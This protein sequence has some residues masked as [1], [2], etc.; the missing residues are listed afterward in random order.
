MAA[1]LDGTLPESRVQRG[2]DVIAGGERIQVRYLGN[3]SGAWVN[4]HLVDLRGEAGS[5]PY[6]CTYHPDQHNPAKIDAS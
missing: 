1:L 4:E 3:P 2:Y 6:Y 5:H